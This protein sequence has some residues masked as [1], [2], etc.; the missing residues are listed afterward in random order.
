MI[1]FNDLKIYAT[2]ISNDLNSKQ[3]IKERGWFKHIPLGF[4]AYGLTYFVLSFTF[5]GV[6]IFI[7]QLITTFLVY[8]GCI[9]FEWA[10]QGS[11]FIDE[12]ERFESNKDAIVGVPP[13]IILILILKITRII[14]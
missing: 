12:L 2:S 11:R 4:L 9:L 1:S 7:Q 8:V 6:P 13:F 14:K 3:T 10:Q 5:D